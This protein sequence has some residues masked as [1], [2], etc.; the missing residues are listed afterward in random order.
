MR[1]IPSTHGRACWWD[2][3][4]FGRSWWWRFLERSRGRPMLSRTLRELF[5]GNKDVPRWV[6]RSRWDSSGNVKGRSLDSMGRWRFQVAALRVASHITKSRLHFLAFVVHLET[7]QGLAI[8]ALD[9]TQALGQRR[10]EVAKAETSR[11]RRWSLGFT[12]TCLSCQTAGGW[13]FDDVIFACL[14]PKESSCCRHRIETVHGDGDCGC[15]EKTR[16]K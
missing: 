1:T 2:S 6:R 11:W 14:T 12:A 9:A 10:S 5:L 16:V 13:R 8:A 4:D 15:C 7:K 3:E